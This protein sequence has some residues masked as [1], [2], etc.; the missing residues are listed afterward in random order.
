MTP[1]RAEAE[2]GSLFP[3]L[4]LY[5]SRCI[6]NTWPVLRSKTKSSREVVNKEI[7]QESSEQRDHT[8]QQFSQAV[9]KAPWS[10]SD[11]LI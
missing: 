6:Q 4:L 8:R 11:I 3:S 2:A 10:L 1:A 5:H 9:N 7:T